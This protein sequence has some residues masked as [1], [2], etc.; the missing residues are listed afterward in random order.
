MPEIQTWRASGNCVYNGDDLGSLVVEC[1]SR[2]VAT[3]L[4][5]YA[6]GSIE[7]R[8]RIA[9]VLEASNE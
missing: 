6:N 5:Q 1:A 8:K 3:A 4:V 7:L 2:A 9:S